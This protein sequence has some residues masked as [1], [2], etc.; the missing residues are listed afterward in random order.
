VALILATVTLATAA[1]DDSSLTSRCLS[2]PIDHI[3]ADTFDGLLRSDAILHLRIA[4]AGYL[5]KL[6]YKG[7]CVITTESRATLLRMVTLSGGPS[8]LLP[9]VRVQSDHGR[10]TAGAEYLV[11]HKRGTPS[12]EVFIE[13]PDYALPMQ[14][15]RVFSFYEPRL[16]IDNGA[17]V[18][19]VMVRLQEVY[20]RHGRYRNYGDRSSAAAF[21]TLL[22]KTGWIAVNTFDTRRGRWTD[23]PPFEFE[24]SSKRSDALPDPGDTILLKAVEPVYILDFGSRGEDLRTQ[25][26]ADGRHTDLAD[27]TGTRA[28]AHVPYTVADVQ[29]GQ[30]DYD[31]CGVVWI[32]LIAK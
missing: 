30:R 2:D 15:G 12:D 9:T 26:P 16:G 19:Q 27:E 4:E 14:G 18:D 17:A 23:G 31:A 3:H 20:N 8:N 13:E 1:G 25:S 21:E 7:G 11:F 5:R 29:C 10:L 32:R 6:R 22:Y 24:S 28:S